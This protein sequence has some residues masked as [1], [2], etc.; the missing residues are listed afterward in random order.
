MLLMLL[1]LVS[2]CAGGIEET[3]EAET[4][5]ADEGKDGTEAL[6]R[7]FLLTGAPLLE[8]TG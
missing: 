7:S 6:G 2:R 8:E 4:N 5:D 1:I 3:E